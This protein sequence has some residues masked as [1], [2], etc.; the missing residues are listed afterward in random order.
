[1]SFLVRGFIERLA[2]L[3]P[4][5]PTYTEFNED[6]QWVSFP[7]LPG[8]D[9]PVFWVKVPGS[10]L[11]VLYSH[12]N[13]EDLGTLMRWITELAERLRVNIVGYDYTGYG[14]RAKTPPSEHYCFRNIRAVYDWLTVDQKVSPQRI[15][16][17]G[18][19]LGSGPT[20]ELASTVPVKAVILQSAFVSAARVVLPMSPFDY[21]GDIFVNWSKVASFKTDKIF[22]IHGDQ[23][24]VV[25]FSHGETLNSLIDEGKRHPPL[26]LQ[27]AGH[28]NVET[29]FLPE[30][31]AGLS[32]FLRTLC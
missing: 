26:F 28:N 1:M 12:G 27:G 11:T 31:Y 8:E 24:R 19:S 14:P 15:V 30:Y 5:P 17:L 32:K 4:F 18:K 9:I 22:M 2:F 16:L 25:P 21:F 13:A 6:L 10:T 20:C 23:D 29:A 3:P 7:E